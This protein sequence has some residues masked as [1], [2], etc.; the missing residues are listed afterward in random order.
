MVGD[1]EQVTPASVGVRTD[2]IDAL[3]DTELQGIPNRRLFDGQTS[4]YDLA[5]ISFG[6]GAVLLREHYRCVPQIIQFSNDLCYDGNLRPL[7]NPSSSSLLPAV[8]SH[9]V[10]GK[11]D[12]LAKT[13]EIEAEEVASL[14]VAHLDLL[15]ELEPRSFG[16]ITLLGASRRV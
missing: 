1:P 7:R 16:V 10:D 9:R 14:L 15:R 8:V 6:R 3:I 12:G 13:N 5:A 2:D 11:R 4:I